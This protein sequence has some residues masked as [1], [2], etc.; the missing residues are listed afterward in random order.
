MRVP[1]LMERVHLTDVNEVYVVIHIDHEAQ[2]ADLL[3]IGNG[4]ERLEC[5]PFAAIEAIPSK[6][7][8]PFQDPSISRG[9][10]RSSVGD[11]G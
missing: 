9:G 7:P 2:A 3:P 8:A 11:R 5:V 6:W 10:G 1:E 4:G